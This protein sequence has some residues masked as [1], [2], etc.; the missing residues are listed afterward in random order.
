M[1]RYSFISI[2]TIATII[3]FSGSVHSSDKV[4]NS[5][6]CRQADNVRLISIEYLDPPKQVPCRVTYEKPNEKS[7][8]YPWS[9]KNQIGYCEEKAKFLAEKLS[10]L[11]LTCNGTKNE[12]DVEKSDT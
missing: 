5:F 7:T 11:G 8:E 12:S 10:S 3:L 1:I 6:I 4:H 2:T 9:A